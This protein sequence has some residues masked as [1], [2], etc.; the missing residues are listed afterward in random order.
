MSAVLVNNNPPF[1]GTDKHTEK[2]PAHKTWFFDATIKE[3]PDTKRDQEEIL[4]K[5][6]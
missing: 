5:H 1:K 2:F 4:Y 3:L 6:F